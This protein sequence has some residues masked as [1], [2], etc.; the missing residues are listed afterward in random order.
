MQHQDTTHKLL[1]HYVCSM[2]EECSFI[3]S[4]A[5]SLIVSLKNHTLT[6]ISPKKTHNFCIGAATSEKTACVSDTH[7]QVLGR[8][9]VYKLYFQ[10]PSQEE[11]Q[12]VSMGGKIPNRTFLWLFHPNFVKKT[13]LKINYCSTYLKA[14]CSF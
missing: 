4:P 6:K 8:C 14:L 5:Q 1:D 9:K 3:K 2:I 12:L 13:L 10:T 11:H 7:K